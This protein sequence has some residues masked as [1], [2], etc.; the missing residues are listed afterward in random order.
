MKI[1]RFV[2]M[3]LLVCAFS[4]VGFYQVLAGDENCANDWVFSYTLDL[5]PDFWA[6]GWHNYTFEL[7]DT[8]GTFEYYTEFYVTDD[9]PHYDGQVFLRFWGVKTAP[10]WTDITEIKPSQDTLFQVTW[11]NTD[12]NRNEAGEIQAGIAVRIKWDDGDWIEVTSG[13]VVNA[14]SWQNPALFVRSWGPTY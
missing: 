3:L 6:T 11:L 8:G 12:V 10:Q 5:P 14:C 4:L 13:P 9:A 7:T 1:I 2:S